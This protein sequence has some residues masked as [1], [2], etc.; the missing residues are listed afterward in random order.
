MSVAREQVDEML[1]FIEDHPEMTQNYNQ[2]SVHEREN[3]NRLWDELR[4]R[5]NSMGYPNKSSGG[6]RKIWA[7]YKYRAKKKLSN[8]KLL[9]RRSGT[10]P[11]EEKTLI[12]KREKIVEL[13]N[14]EAAV[15]GYEDILLFDAATKSFINDEFPSTSRIMHLIDLA[16][17]DDIPT[18]TKKLRCSFQNED[19]KMKMTQSAICD[20]FREQVDN[21]QI[22]QKQVLQMMREKNQEE[23]SFHTKMLK[24]IKNKHDFLL[25]QTSRDFKSDISEED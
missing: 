25:Q 2:S 11:I 8:D 3:L 13:A 10:V 6:W 15:D 16:S 1:H 4:T 20:L 22:H 14:L 19:T 24:L 17:R 23:K 9:L 12:V 7:D 5:L 21:Q 18:A